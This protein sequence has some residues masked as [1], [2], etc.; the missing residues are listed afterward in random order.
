MRKLKL[1]NAETEICGRLRYAREHVAKVS[2]AECAA[3][4]NQDRSTLA[5]YETART[6][7]RWEVALRFCRQFIISE[8]WLAT[9]RFGLAQNAVKNKIETDFSAEKWLRFGE[10]ISMRQC[11]DLFSE[12]ITIRLKPGA[13]FSEAFET[14]LKERYAE[15]VSNNA[16]D[17]RIIFSSA[18]NPSIGLNFLNA[19]NERNFSSLLSE[20]SQSP[21]GQNAAWRLY[22][23]YVN[24][25][26]IAIHHRFFFGERPQEIRVQLGEVS[27]PSKQSDWE[28]GPSI[29]GG[30]YEETKKLFDYVSEVRNIEEVKAKFPDLLERLKKITQERGKKTALAKFLGV[31]LS[32]VSQWLS[33]EYEPGGETTLQML[34]WV[35]QQERQK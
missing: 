30:S 13:L 7:L 17:P 16:F 12:D 14:V 9:G 29:M 15:L 4:I 19:A 23:L 21:T 8:E 1:P 10:Q 33:G 2:Q 24:E 22:S 5:N 18:D 6:P 27:D 3:Q 26:A 25:C 31:K 20:W 11:M 34:Q 35:E 32:R 28:I